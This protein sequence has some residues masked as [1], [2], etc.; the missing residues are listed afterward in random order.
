LGIGVGKEDRKGM[1]KVYTCFKWNT[2]RV[3]G[4]TF[5]WGVDFLV[6]VDVNGVGVGK[7][8]RYGLVRRA[9]RGL[10]LGVG[11]RKVRGERAMGLSGLESRGRSGDGEEG[12]PLLV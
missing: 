1:G 3:L 8:G 4:M 11:K 9:L 12:K 10:H 5:C 6:D 7:R 2:V